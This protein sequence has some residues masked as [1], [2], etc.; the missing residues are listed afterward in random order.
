MEDIKIVRYTNNGISYII[1]ANSSY[2]DFDALKKY[3]R[4]FNRFVI[5]PK[6]DYVKDGIFSIKNFHLDFKKNYM[7]GNKLFFKNVNFCFNNYK[8]RAKFCNTLLLNI[9]I[10]K[11]KNVKFFRLNKLEKTKIRYTFVINR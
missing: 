7:I 4:Y 10:I 2:K 1:K 11:C 6:Y 9:N 5:I 3:Y 8:I